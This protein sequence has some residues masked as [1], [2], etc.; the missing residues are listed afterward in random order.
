MAA[1]THPQ[2]RRC[3]TRL[4]RGFFPETERE[5]FHVQDDRKAFKFN[6]CAVVG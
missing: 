6:N 4:R 3:G 1:I 5:Y 2:L